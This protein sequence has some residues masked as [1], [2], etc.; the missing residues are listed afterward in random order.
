MSTRSTIAVPIIDQS[1]GVQ[2][3]MV[4]I[5]KLEGNFEESDAGILCMI[6]RSLEGAIRSL[7]VHQNRDLYL[8]RLHNML[9][10]T[11]RMS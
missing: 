11:M 9:T 8:N 2:G 6:A 4:A 10:S 5:N 1:G 7:K 3:V